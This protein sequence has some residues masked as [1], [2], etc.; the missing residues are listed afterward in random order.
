MVQLSICIPTYNRANYLRDLLDKITD[1]EIPDS[2][3]IV[4]DNHS[5]DNTAEIF[6]DHKYK[7][8]KFFINQENIGMVNNWNRCIEQASGEYILLISSDD[9]VKPELFIE[10][11]KYIS[12]YPECGLIFSYPIIINADGEQIGVN[13]NLRHNLLFKNAAFFRLLIGFNIVMISGALVKKE[14][15]QKLGQFREGTLYTD[16]DMWLRVSLEYPILYLDKPLFF[17]RVHPENLLKRLTKKRELKDTILIYKDILLKLNNKRDFNQ[18]IK[19]L[20]ELRLRYRIYK[21]LT[22]YSTKNLSP[23]FAKRIIKLQ[24][25]NSIV[26]VLNFLRSNIQKHNLASNKLSFKVL[27]YYPVWGFFLL[28]ACLKLYL[29]PNNYNFN[30]LNS[31]GFFLKRK[32]Y[33]S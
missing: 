16:W 18:H 32:V 14:V 1:F 33:S 20:T 21:Y 17:Y 10:Y 8:I 2:E 15:Y 25:K 6:T 22:E 3:I 31:L 26:I 7:K 24:L 23:K 13:R 27:R 29:R 30:I 19:Y 5:T 11:Q 12:K 4:I 9:L 28:L